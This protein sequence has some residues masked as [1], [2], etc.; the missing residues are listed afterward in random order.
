MEIN[1]PQVFNRFI[2]S[3]GQI[4]H[5]TIIPIGVWDMDATASV[6]VNHSF[7]ASFT[8]IIECIGMIFEDGNVSITPMNQGVDPVTKGYMGA[9]V[10]GINS[11]IISLQRRPAGAFDN[12]AYNDGVMNRGYLIIKYIE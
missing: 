6:D 8:K 3:S 1:N 9:F 11:T 10:S 12:T 7:G 2:C 5:I 4:M